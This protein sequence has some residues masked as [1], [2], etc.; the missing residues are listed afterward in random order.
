MQRL[1]SYLAR[2]RLWSLGY[3]LAAG[4]I[5]A[6]L[7]ELGDLS[8][9]IGHLQLLFLSAAIATLLF[10]AAL[11][12]GRQAERRAQAAETRLRDA[13]ESI[14]AGFA[15]FDSEDRLVISNEMHKRMYER[16]REFMI[17]GVRFA[18]ILR[19][20]AKRGHHPE[21]VGRIDEW[22]AER[23]HKHLNPGDP[24]EQDRG[25]GQWLLIGERRTSEG[26]IV[27]TWTDVSQLKRQ[28]RLLRSSEE[29]LSSALQMLQTLIEIC[30]LAIIEVGRDLAVRSWNPAAEAIFGWMASEVI[31]K[32]LPIM[33]PDQ[34][35]QV[36]AETLP[37]LEQ[38]PIA[39][40]EA[41]RRHKDGRPIS[42]ALWVT[43]RRDH[44]GQAESYVAFV[45]DVSERKRME[46]ELRRS[47]RMQAMGQLTGGIAHEFNNLL[48]II[49]GNMEIMSS[50]LAGHPGALRQAERVL[51]A[52][53]RGATLTQ[54]LLAYAR[55]QTLKPEAIS[56]SQMLE[57]LQALARVSVGDSVTLHI[58]AEADISRINADRTQLETALLN[59]IINAREALPDSSGAI[60]VRARNMVLDE[61]TAG[62]LGLAPGDYVA[63]EVADNGSGMMPDVLA[64]AIEPFFTTKE[65]GQG[66]G[67]GLSMVHGFVQQ[68]GGHLHI[69]SQVDAG[70]V[71]R[72]LLPATIVAAP[73]RTADD[74]L[75]PR[76]GLR[77]LIVEDEPAV[78]EI[79]VTR[80]ES[81]GYQTLSASGGPAALR[82]IDRV[83]APDILFT[84]VAMP[85]GM[86]GVDLA[87]SILAK[88]PEVRVVFTTGHN[89][90]IAALDGNASGMA[91]LRKP[92]LKAEL[93][94]VLRDCLAAAEPGA[95]TGQVVPF[96]FTS[97]RPQSARNSTGK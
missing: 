68:S 73:S 97:P 22:V 46:E 53:Q 93:A 28:E 82:L 48:L 77:V 85:G 8:R 14:G 18:D 55:R 12:S 17:P 27:G 86:S 45:A 58:A 39:E 80:I 24:F 84:D 72:V 96:P 16:N 60:V 3:A 52:A 61:E 11:I 26:G 37:K 35:E 67:L 76:G 6:G 83:G 54:Q 2:P 43:A 75:A 70:T 66:P 95:T 30:P 33:T 41:E 89:E 13:I 92:Y 91:V 65:V 87:R 62:E 49:L 20:S 50:A 15:L 78:L 38:M 42:V 63:I 74:D 40:M 25:N 59:L 4:A 34:L 79:S 10:A 19:S 81:L 69:E 57:E 21:A 7:G 94:Q 44:S 64:R 88:F 29:R 9:A 23:L 32:P 90:Q 5:F 1:T 47:H 36:R 51:K 31:G 56:V 71:V